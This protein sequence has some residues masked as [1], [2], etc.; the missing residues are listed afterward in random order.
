MK[1][2]FAILMLLLLPLSLLGCSK[3][4]EF[5]APVSFYY[6]RAPMP[7]GEVVHGSPDS[8][9]FA[10]IRESAGRE[11]DYEYLLKLYLTGPQDERYESPFPRS[12]FLTEFKLENGIATLVLTDNLAKLTGIDLSLACGCLTMTVLEMTDAQLVIIQTENELLNG[13]D[14]LIY[15]RDS[16]LLFDDTLPEID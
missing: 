15:Q 11:T 12:T 13:K 10:D 6:L 9:I 1:R 2:I 3:E 8:V 14:R 7:N 16:F 5:A 4:P